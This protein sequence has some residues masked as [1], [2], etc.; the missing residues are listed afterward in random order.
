VQKRNE[1]TVTL[2]AAVGK[3]ASHDHKADPGRIN[4]AAGLL[5]FTHVEGTRMNQ[6][7]T[8]LTTLVHG[9]TILRVIKQ[10]KNGVRDDRNAR[11]RK[12]NPE[13]SKAGDRNIRGT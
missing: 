1:L 11:A 13:C 6:K 8:R 2:A 5:T 3:A 4:G 9:A 12:L 10:L 7:R